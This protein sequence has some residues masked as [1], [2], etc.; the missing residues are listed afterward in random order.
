MQTNIKRDRQ[1]TRAVAFKHSVTVAVLHKKRKSELKLCREPLRCFC[2]PHLGPLSGQ[3]VTTQGRVFRTWCKWGEGK[4]GVGSEHTSAS[5]R[6]GISPGQQHLCAPE[7]HSQ[8]TP[9]TVTRK[10]KLSTH[11]YVL[12]PGIYLYMCECVYTHARAR[13]HTRAL[14]HTYPAHYLCAP[15]FVI[16]PCNSAFF[17]QLSSPTITSVSGPC[18]KTYDTTK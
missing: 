12:A 7:G 15:G 3:T 9:S 4:P 11:D 16:S 6:A 8:V 10:S 1:M 17:F 18:Q 13:A 14:T 2:T 5:R